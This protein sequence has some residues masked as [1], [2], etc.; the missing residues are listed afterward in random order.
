MKN[1]KLFYPKLSYL[2]TGICFDVHNKLGRYAKEKQ[3]GNLLENEFK[4]NNLTYKREY[5]TEIT[6][7]INIIDFLINNKIIIEIKA[8]KVIVRDD[9]YQ[10]QRYLQASKIKLGLLI[11]FRDRYLKPIRVIRID[12]DVRKKFI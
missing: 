7:N 11:N 12:T 3:Y 8:K 6:N 4:K 2:I 5:K 1:D 10:L 9:Y